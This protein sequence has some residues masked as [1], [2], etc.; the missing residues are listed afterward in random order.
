MAL[1]SKNVGEAPVP[2]DVTITLPAG[3]LKINYDEERHG[4]SVDDE[5][6]GPRWPGVPGG[7]TVTITPASG[8]APLVVMEPKG[9]SEYSTLKRVG[10]RLGKIE[11]P[12]AGE[13][14]VS[15]PPIPPSDRELYGPILKFKT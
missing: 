11:V 9:I 14:V 2:G 7:L 12:A 3:K 1:F 8:G 13:Y 5:S 6:S 10:S 15:V 4:R